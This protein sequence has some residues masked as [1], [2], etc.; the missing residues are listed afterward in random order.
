[1]N[2]TWVDEIKKWAAKRPHL[3]YSILENSGH[4]IS[5]EHPGVV[6]KAITDMIERSGTLLPVLRS[7]PLNKQ[8]KT[9]ELLCFVCNKAKL[10]LIKSGYPNT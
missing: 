3:Q 4:H 7:L 2:F 5:K 6:I 10:V 9:V 1:M 8:I